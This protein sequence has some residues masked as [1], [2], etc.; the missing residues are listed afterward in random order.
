MNTEGG[1]EC[2]CPQGNK[3]VENICL[4][5]DECEIADDSGEI[6]CPLDTQSCKN[7]KKADASSE[8]FVCFCE[9]SECFNNLCDDGKS[10]HL[11]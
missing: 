5:E 6:I 9:N 3:L 2:E 7:V 1:Y 4:D 8:G 10:S 11:H